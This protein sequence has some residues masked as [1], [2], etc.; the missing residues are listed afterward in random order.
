MCLY[1]EFNA[2]PGRHKVG[3]AGRAGKARQGGQSREGK[4]GEA[5]EACKARQGKARQTNADEAGEACEA[6][7]AG[8]AGE[9]CE[10]SPWPWAPASL[11]DILQHGLDDFAL[12][13]IQHATRDV[14]QQQSYNHGLY[15]GDQ[16]TLSVVACT[17]ITRY[18]AVSMTSHPTLIVPCCVIMVCLT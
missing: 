17:R 5:D 3:E 10:G 9:A 13:G 16:L 15:Y 2:R 6:D 14:H 11:A 18:D 4:A 12:A 8:N 7:E 1:D